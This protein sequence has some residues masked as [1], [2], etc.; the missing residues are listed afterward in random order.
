VPYVPA[1][2][3]GLVTTMILA[4]AV[5]GIPGLSAGWPAVT[6]VAGLLSAALL[7]TFWNPHLAFGLTLDAAIIVIAVSRPHWAQHL[8]T[9]S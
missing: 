5:R 1:P 2:K 6:L 7:I 3:P 4:F 8:L 9:A